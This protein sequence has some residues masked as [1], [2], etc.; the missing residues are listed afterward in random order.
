MEIDC[1]W[2][3]ADSSFSLLNPPIPNEGRRDHFDIAC[4]AWRKSSH[5]TCHVR[6]RE[7]GKGKEDLGNGCMDYSKLHACR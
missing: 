4:A 7:E 1:I 2:N 5:K 6:K 3:Q